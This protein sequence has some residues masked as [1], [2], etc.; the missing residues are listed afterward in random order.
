[1]S[2]PSQAP[3]RQRHG[4]ACRPRLRRLNDESLGCQALQ[5][6]LERL[7]RAQLDGRRQLGLRGARRQQHLGAVVVVVVVGATCVGFVR[8]VW[9]LIT[10]TRGS[11][12]LRRT[13]V[14]GAGGGEPSIRQRWTHGLLARNGG[15]NKAAC[16]FRV[17]ARFD[18]DYQSAP[19]RREAQTSGHAP[20]AG[21]PLA[22]GSRSV[23]CL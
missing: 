22:P 12:S 14:P 11:C 19:R 15:S 13:A 9:A 18:E 17:F 7:E 8:R 2:A 1:M 23:R 3:T 4:C 6:A 16:C 5:H 20:A 21:S 10:T